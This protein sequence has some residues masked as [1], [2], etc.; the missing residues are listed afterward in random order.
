MSIAKGT[1][2]V[3]GPPRA[4]VKKLVSH[5]KYLEYRPRGAEETRADRTFFS[6]QRDAVGRHQVI[7]AVMEHT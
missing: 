3:K 2:F 4:V 5:A 7:D 1:G 6:E